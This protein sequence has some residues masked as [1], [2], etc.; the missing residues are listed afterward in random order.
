MLWRRG[1]QAGIEGL[2]AHQLRHT[3]AHAWL[4]QGGLETD[5]MR[6]RRLAVTRDAPA[7]RGLGRRRPRP[8]GAPTSLASGPAVEVHSLLLGER[9]LYCRH[10]TN[11]QRWCPMAF[12]PLG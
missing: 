11:F 5:L 10:E 1:R 6:D 3:F 9:R 8:R 7:L 2:H 4:A 12:C